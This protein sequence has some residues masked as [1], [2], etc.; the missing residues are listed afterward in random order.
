[1]LASDRWVAT[2]RLDSRW[3]NWFWFCFKAATGNE[4]AMGW[5]VARPSIPVPLDQHV[6]ADKDIVFRRQRGIFSTPRPVGGVLVF[7]VR[8]LVLSSDVSSASS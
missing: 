5:T 8:V 1:M 6:A 2:A 3:H 4:F 7:G